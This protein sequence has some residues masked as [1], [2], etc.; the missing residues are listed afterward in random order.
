MQHEPRPQRSTYDFSRLKK[1]FSGTV[2][3][4]ENFT[5]NGIEWP[6][7]KPALIPLDYVLVKYIKDR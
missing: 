3:N 7:Y 4:K 2:L 1:L 6:P 5:G